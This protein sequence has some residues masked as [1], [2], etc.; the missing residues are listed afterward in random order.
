M[1]EID[2]GRTLD[3]V[4]DTDTN[5]YLV[6]RATRGVAMVVDGRRDRFLAKYLDYDLDLFRVLDFHVATFTLSPHFV[7]MHISILC[8]CTEIYKC[9]SPAIDDRSK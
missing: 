3:F 7:C 4:F 6:H 5:N 8:L 2:Q 9:T 1:G